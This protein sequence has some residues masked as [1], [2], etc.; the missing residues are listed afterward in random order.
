MDG[1][2]LHKRPPNESL[3]PQMQARHSSGRFSRYLIAT[4]IFRRPPRT[5]TTNYVSVWHVCFLNWRVQ[6]R[7]VELNRRS[8]GTHACPPQRAAHF[9]SLVTRNESATGA[10]GNAMGAVLRGLRPC[11]L[12][13]RARWPNVA[14]SHDRP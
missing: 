6:R 4:P 11:W 8:P 12:V 13:S 10:C 1:V 14:V 5:C 7:Y 2:E 9:P 3:S